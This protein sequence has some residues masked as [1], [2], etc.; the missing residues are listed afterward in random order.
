[1]S[2]IVITGKDLTLEQIALICRENVKNRV[3]RGGK[4]EHY[5]I[6]KSG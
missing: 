4:T 6:K 3:S 2:N 5:R 1:M